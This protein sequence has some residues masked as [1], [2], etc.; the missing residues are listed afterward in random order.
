MPAE[1]SAP[2]LIEPLPGT[3]GTELL[4]RLQGIEARAAR[5]FPASHLPEALRGGVTPLGDLR[6]GARAGWLRVAR[7]PAG[8]PVGFALAEPAGAALHLLEMDV[9]PEHGGRGIG[10]ALLRA[11]VADACAAG[12]RAVTLTTFR[13]LPWNAPFYAR[14]GFEVLEGDALAPRLRRLLEAEARLGVD[15]TLRVAMERRLRIPGA[16]ADA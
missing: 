1:P 15:S 7:I 14:E 4:A 16:D 8:D 5:L 13:D 10:R 11:V 3:P 12:F 6:A 9:E 2:A